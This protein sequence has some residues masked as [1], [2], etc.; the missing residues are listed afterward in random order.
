MNYESDFLC[1]D[2]SLNRHPLR[3]YPTPVLKGDQGDSAYQLRQCFAQSKNN[4]VI[5]TYGG[6]LGFIEALPDYQE[7]L[8][9]LQSGK[10]SRHITVV[11][12]GSICGKPVNTFEEFRSW[13]PF[14]LI[15]VLKLAT[16]GRIAVPW[17]EVRDQEGHLVR[18]FHP[19]FGFP[20]YRKGHAA[21][22][23]AMNQGIGDLI[24]S[25]QTSEHLGKPAFRIAANHLVESWLDGLT[26]EDRMFHFSKVIEVLSEQFDLKKSSVNSILPASVLSEVKCLLKKTKQQISGIPHK[27]E[28][29]INEDAEKLLQRIAN[30]V[31]N[32]WSFSV[33]FGEQTVRLIE[34][35][36]FPDAAI[37]NA[38][39]GI[40]PRKDGKTWS[41]TLTR[42]RSEVVHEMHFRISSGDDHIEDIIQIQRH[43]HDILMRILLKM[44]NYDGTYQPVLKIGS[45]DSPLDWVKPDTPASELGYID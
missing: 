18:R 42:L 3:V 5:F 28:T 37:I 9:S 20:N 15:D 8:E 21:I 10:C 35:F 4:L 13:F 34:K 24:S 12:V 11:M 6:E 23:G 22:D 44:L 1:S 43:L 31:E 16:G 29:P 36:E 45:T 41:D 7:K 2:P 33:S 39:F 17:I 30:R 40:H 26:I 25:S 27:L 14:H 38:H 19:K 32:G